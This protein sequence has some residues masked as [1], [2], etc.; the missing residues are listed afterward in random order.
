MVTLNPNLAHLISEFPTAGSRDETSDSH[1]ARTSSIPATWF[2]RALAFLRPLITFFLVL[3][4]FL[5]AVRFGLIAWKVERVLDVDGLLAVMLNGLR[6]DVLVLS[7]V[8]LPVVIVLLIL[9]N[10]GR[11]GRWVR[12]AVSLYMVFFLWFFVFQEAATPAFIEEYDTRPN[13]LL[14]EY[15]VHPREVFSMLWTGYRM[16]LAGCLALTIAVVWFGW[17]WIHKNLHRPTHLGLTHR[18]ALFLVLIP[19]LFLGARSS[20]QHRGANPS[21]VAFSSDHLVNVLGLSSGYSVLYAAYSLRSES[22]A[23]RNYGYL[24]HDAIVDEVRADMLTVAPQ[25][26]IESATPTLH[27]QV[28]PPRAEGPLNLVVILEESMGARFVGDLG[29]A[30]LTPSLDALAKESWTFEQMY[31]TGTRSVRGIEAIVSGFQPTPS[32]SVVKLG[33]SQHG[34][35]TIADLLK[36]QGYKTQFIYGGE[37]HFDNM[38]G[39]FTGNGFQDIVDQDDYVDPVFHGSWGVSDQDILR[40]AHEEFEAMGDEPFFSLVFSV[41]NHS[42][43]EF[44]EG[45]VDFPEGPHDTRENGIRY[46]DGALGMFFD[47]ARDS[48]YWDRTVFVVI[49]DHDSRVY[50]ADLVP[51]EH[52]HIPCLILGPGIEPH[53]DAR[54]AS[55]LDVGPTVLSLM[56]V[57]SIH[58]MIGRDMTQ[59]P[60]DAEGRAIMQYGDNQAFLQGDQVVV[61][62]PH[63]EPVQFQQGKTLVPTELD[64]ALARRAL[65]HALLPTWLYKSRLY[66]LPD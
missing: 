8:L 44:P 13:R 37:S 40:R 41:S 31:A 20:L 6:M 62:Q 9:G 56:G 30:D 38:K 64:P 21:T 60:A 49:A 58:P 14:L 54:I 34:F 15:L 4:V 11:T 7:I 65:A 46:A 50:G 51:I 16:E 52:Y 42:P 28:V 17:K 53:R 57:S 5:S 19:T 48:S 33:N 61:L 32:R 23:A 24:V 45:L 35:F 25:D 36:R 3:M 10:E 55:Q 12:N 26:F 43:F 47:L 18:L 29:G 39:F 59:L 22:D 1:S 63:K 66:H 2:G 27:H